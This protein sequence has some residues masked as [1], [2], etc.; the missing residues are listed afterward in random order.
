MTIGTVKLGKLFIKNYSKPRSRKMRAIGE[1][2]ENIGTIGAA[3][4][5][6]AT[7]EGLKWFGIAVF[8]MGKI[9]NLLT[10]LSKADDEDLIDEMKSNETDDKIEQIN[11]SN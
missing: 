3:P 6:F 2:M 9:G 7:D 4:A 11:K 10:K 8:V 1:W 5:I